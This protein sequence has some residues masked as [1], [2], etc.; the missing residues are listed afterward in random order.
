MDED[1]NFK[2]NG[3]IFNLDMKEKEPMTQEQLDA[4]TAAI[5]IFVRERYWYYLRGASIVHKE[6]LLT[7]QR[8]YSLLTYINIVGTFLV[9]GSCDANDNIQVNTFVRLGAGSA[10]QIKPIVIQ[11]SVVELI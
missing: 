4:K 3:E 7:T 6:S 11:P 8:V 2:I 5:D 9:I 10:D 1:G